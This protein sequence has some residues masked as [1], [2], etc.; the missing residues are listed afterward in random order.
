MLTRWISLGRSRFSI[1]SS[2]NQL[3]IK[4]CVQINVTFG[5]YF[6]QYLV[7]LITAAGDFN[8]LLHQQGWHIM[9]TSACG[10]HQ[11]VVFS[12]PAFSIT[13]SKNIHYNATVGR[14]GLIHIA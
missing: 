8:L 11:E 4:Q 5:R 12:M 2:R 6:N 3:S 14:A 7:D 9:C 13:Q 1:L 10:F